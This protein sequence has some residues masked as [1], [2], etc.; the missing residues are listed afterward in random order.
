MLTEFYFF[1]K[2]KTKKFSCF[3]QYF[4]ISTSELGPAQLYQS[5]KIFQRQLRPTF[6]EER[7]ETIQDNE[8]NRPN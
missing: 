2:N 5:E 6:L 3:I 1:V 8:T 7:T 4:F